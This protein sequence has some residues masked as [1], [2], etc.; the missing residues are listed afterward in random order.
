MT[1]KIQ[2]FL[3]DMGSV[4]RLQDDLEDLLVLLEE[5]SPLTEAVEEL[6]SSIDDFCREASQLMDSA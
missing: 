4:G 2:A 5:D 3:E 1:E 6:L